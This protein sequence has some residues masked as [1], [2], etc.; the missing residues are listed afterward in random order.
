MAKL[1]AD[2]S[3]RVGLLA[4]GSLDSSEGNYYHQSLLKKLGPIAQLVE[5]PAHNRLVPGSSPGGPTISYERL[6]MKPPRVFQPH[7][8]FHHG[9]LD[10]A[11]RDLFEGRKTCHLTIGDTG[12][13]VHN[14]NRS[15]NPAYFRVSRSWLSNERMRIARTSRYTLYTSIERCVSQNERG[16]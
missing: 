1:Y 6:L 5:P 13:R 10:Q 7:L 14:G 3:P 15:A 16:T 8:D 12:S 9:E 4:P 11:P 2:V